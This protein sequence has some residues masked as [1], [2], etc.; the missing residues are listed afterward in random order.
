M[1]RGILEIAVPLGSFERNQGRNLVIL[2]P[3]D[4]LES[5]NVA[6]YGVILIKFIV[7][8]LRIIIHGMERRYAGL[9]IHRWIKGHEKWIPEVFIPIGLLRSSL[10]EKD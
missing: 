8:K 9:E 6:L 3:L 10:G 2:F 5:I 1:K 7:M 4:F